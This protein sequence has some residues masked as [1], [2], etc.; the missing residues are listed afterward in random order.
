MVRM[1]TSYF[2]RM[3][4]WM[5]PSAPSLKKITAWI[6]RA[7]SGRLINPSVSLYVVEVALRM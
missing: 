4:T 3:L 7:V 6:S 2:E 5:S 1:S